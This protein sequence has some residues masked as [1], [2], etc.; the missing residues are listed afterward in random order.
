MNSLS[1]FK[2]PSSRL[3]VYSP[4]V[5]CRGTFERERLAEFAA[6]GVAVLLE[7]DR[8]AAARFSAAETK[9]HDLKIG[10]WP[11]DREGRLVLFRLTGRVTDD[12]ETEATAE[13]HASLFDPDTPREV[14]C[15]AILCARLMRA[16]YD[17][18]SA[19]FR[20][21]ARTLLQPSVVRWIDEELEKL[22]EAP[23]LWRTFVE[24]YETIGVARGW[25]RSTA[26]TADALKFQSK[27]EIESAVATRPVVDPDEKPAKGKGRKVPK[28]K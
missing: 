27:D 8:E 1:S 11:K 22:T 6:S 16:A 5:R 19:A 15:A 18:Q 13:F 3:T 7:I 10:V 17:A 20:D 23:D 2:L 21:P 28:S 12:D 14:L 26:A 25:L 24:R 4:L 9:G